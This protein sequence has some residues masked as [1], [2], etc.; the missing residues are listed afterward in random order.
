MSLEARLRALELE[1]YRG[2]TQ[3]TDEAGNLAW[4][5]GSGLSLLREITRLGRLQDL[6]EDDQRLAWLWSRAKPDESGL[7]E[8]VIEACREL[9]H[10]VVS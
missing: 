6:T 9:V 8:M 1:A 5:Q 2:L 10:E 3:T 7:S 4:L